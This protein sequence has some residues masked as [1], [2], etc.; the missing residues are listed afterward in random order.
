MKLKNSVAIMAL[1]LFSTLAIAQIDATTETPPSS[2][3]TEKTVPKLNIVWNCGDCTQNEKVIPLIEDTYR[4]EAAKDGKVISE[5]ES[6]DVAIVT[7]RQRPPGRRVMMGVFAGK[8][9]LELK[10]NYKGNESSASDYSANVLQG[11]NHL[12]ES[13][14]KRA[15]KNISATTK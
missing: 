7:Y 5:T 11:M 12:C 14:G 4:S 9:T 3:T 6:A 10:I 1:G 13:V 15:Y 8:D 2:G